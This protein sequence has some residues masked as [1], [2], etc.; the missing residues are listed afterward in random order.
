MPIIKGTLKT[1]QV[2]VRE[3]DIITS[4]LGSSAS[5][6]DARGRWH[7]THAR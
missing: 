3:G 4:S 6:D 1:G 7:D 2:I 5:V